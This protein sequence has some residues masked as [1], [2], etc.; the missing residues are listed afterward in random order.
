MP[1]SSSTCRGEA[2]EVDVAPGA[3]AGGEGAGLDLVEAGG[4]AG[5]RK[6][7]EVEERDD[8]DDRPLVPDREARD[9]PERNSHRVARLPEV[10]DDHA[11]ARAEAERLDDLERERHRHLE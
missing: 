6:T 1:R 9:Y 2:S 8:V 3:D 7:E 5:R 10:V 11:G 4:R